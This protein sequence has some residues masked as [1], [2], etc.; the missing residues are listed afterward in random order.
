MKEEKLTKE[1]LEGYLNGLY[2]IDTLAEEIFRYIKSNYQ[3]YLEFG[4]Y[5]CLDEWK[6]DED[7]LSIKYYDHG[8][9]LYEYR[10]FEDI[11]VDTLLNDTWKAFIDDHFN[12]LKAKKEANKAASD[13]REK[14]MRKK[15]FEE[16]KQEFE[17][18]NK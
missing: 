4:R 3:E 8:Y 11:P 10:W 9:D 14:E 13:A 5:S 18:G 7:E 1:V 12:K 16:L 15:L 6:L 17:D 2:I